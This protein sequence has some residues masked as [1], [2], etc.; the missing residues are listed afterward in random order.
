MRPDCPGVRGATDPHGQINI[1]A[2][3]PDSDT[4]RTA[5]S[6]L[7]RISRT[8]P[9]AAAVDRRRTVAYSQ[10]RARRAD[11]CRFTRS[12]GNS[13]FFHRRHSVVVNAII[14]GVNVAARPLVRVR[15]HV[16]RSWGRYESLKADAPLDPRR[17][18]AYVTKLL[19]TFAF[20]AM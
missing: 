2:S 12:V 15:G 14:Y 9:A 18:S 17:L 19:E 4:K 16:M 5:T 7:L 8:L 13:L 1:P 10:S 20:A 11:L 6:T 3:D